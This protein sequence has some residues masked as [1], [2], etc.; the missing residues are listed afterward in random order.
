MVTI[1]A[2]VAAKKAANA[3]AKP[4][5]SVVNQPRSPMGTPNR[6]SGDRPTCGAVGEFCAVGWELCVIQVEY[7]FTQEYVQD[8][9]ESTQTKLPEGLGSGGTVR[10]IDVAHSTPARLAANGLR[11]ASFGDTGIEAADLERM[12]LAV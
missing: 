6:V 11:Y 5:R 4:I 3:D 2:K 8:M 1:P 12:I 10:A 9:Q 7:R